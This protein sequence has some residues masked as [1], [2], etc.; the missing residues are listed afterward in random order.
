MVGLEEAC[1]ASFS[2]G[3]PHRGQSWKEKEEETWRHWHCHLEMLPSSG[4][5]TKVG[6]LRV[7][8]VGSG[9]PAP[10]PS[11][12]LRVK[13]LALSAPQAGSLPVVSA[14]DSAQMEHCPCPDPDLC[15]I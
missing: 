5:A 9:S 8:H 14:L 1:S 3:R 12:L 6:E 7:P 4:H 2:S 10:E 15:T 13:P 11:C